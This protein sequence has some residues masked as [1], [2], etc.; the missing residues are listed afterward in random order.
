MEKLERVR[1]EKS[2]YA[3]FVSRVEK[4]LSCIDV[5]DSEI[6]AMQDKS[7]YYV[8]LSIA[9]IRRKIAVLKAEIE[10][11]AYPTSETEVFRCGNIRFIKE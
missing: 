5:A 6:D 11:F 3:E 10:E 8:Q 7:D 1:G 4:A 9:S 2:P